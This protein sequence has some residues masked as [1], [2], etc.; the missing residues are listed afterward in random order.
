MSRAEGMLICFPFEFFS[1]MK[2][3]RLRGC[4]E[5]YLNWKVLPLFKRFRFWYC[6]MSLLQGHSTSPSLQWDFSC[7]LA[8]KRL[9]EVAW[10][11]VTHSIFHP[12]LK[13]KHR[14]REKRKPRCYFWS[15]L[16]VVSVLLVPLLSLRW[17]NKI[18]SQFLYSPFHFKSRVAF[19]IIHIR[20]SQTPQRE[21]IKP[22]QTILHTAIYCQPISF[23]EAYK[24]TW[25]H[26]RMRC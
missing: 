13:A 14:K 23:P 2:K 21:E 20:N 12:W 4:L 18:W 17:F 11:C 10:V 22:K 25:R 15:S 26:D 16:D 8:G 7:F 24:V 5:D 9:S 3:A 19:W 1:Y 6:P